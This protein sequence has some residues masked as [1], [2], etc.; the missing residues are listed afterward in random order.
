MH[1]FD[2]SMHAFDISMHENEKKVSCM[3]MSFSCMKFHLFMHES[4]IFI[5]EIFMSRLFMHV[6][7]RTGSIQ[8]GDASTFCSYNL[9]VNER[10]KLK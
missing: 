9:N 5:P 3:K 2:I 6:R 1:E 10:V 4:E 7:F 8:L